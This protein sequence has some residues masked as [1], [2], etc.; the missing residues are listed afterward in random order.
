MAGVNRHEDVIEDR[1]CETLGQ[2]MVHE[3]EIQAKPHSILV[4][5][6]MI[7]PGWEVASSVEIDVKPELAD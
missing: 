6:A 4:T 2:Q 5:F 7:C 1:K 3:S